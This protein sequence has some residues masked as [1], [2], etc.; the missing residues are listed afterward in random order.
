MSARPYLSFIL[1]SRNDNYGG[2]LTEKLELSLNFLIDQLTDHQLDAEIIIVEWNPPSDEPLLQRVLRLRRSD[3]VSVRFIMVPGRF[4]RRLRSWNKMP[5][6]PVSAINVGIRRARGQFVMA[7]ASD[8]FYSEELVGFLARRELRQDR[9][10]RMNRV[11]VPAEC[12]E[13]PAGDRNAFLDHCMAS[14]CTEHSELER[15]YY[16]G[17]VSLHTNGCGDFMLASREAWEQVRGFPEAGSAVPLD[18]DGLALYALFASGL[19]QEILPPPYRTLKIRHGRLGHRN[20]KKEE[21]LTPL[22][23]DFEQTLISDID[24]ELQRAGLDIRNSG[25]LVRFLVRLIFDEPRREMPGLGIVD[26]P[27]SA[28]YLYRTW[29]LSERRR[30]PIIAKLRRLPRFL[31]EG[32][33]AEI[34]GVRRLRRRLAIMVWHIWADYRRLDRRLFSYRRLVGRLYYLAALGLATRPYIVNGRQWG[35]AEVDDLLDRPPA[36]FLD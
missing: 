24:R 36:L 34:K 23:G 12:L 31:N 26:H 16:A 7:R 4:H 11:D 33:A 15:P 3:R 20:K 25:D 22:V 13:T 28:E 17:R 5:G 6:S 9:V 30:C 10:Y 1:Y 27:S 21:P 14:D 2:D 29:L 32:V 8:V 35:L 19:D 18:S